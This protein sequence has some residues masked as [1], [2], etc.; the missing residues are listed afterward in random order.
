MKKI[1]TA[2]NQQRG[3]ADGGMESENGIRKGKKK[4]SSGCLGICLR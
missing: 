2:P 4:D 3:V 1:E